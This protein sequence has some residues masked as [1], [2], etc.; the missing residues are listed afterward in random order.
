MFFNCTSHWAIVNSMSGIIITS[1]R[2]GERF[3]EL[4]RGTQTGRRFEKHILSTG[5]LLYP[6]VAGGK[7]NIDE[8]FLDTMIKNFNNKVCDIV[9]LPVA[10]SKNEHTED[11]L[12]NIGEVIQLTKRNGKLYAEMDVRDDTAAPKVGKTLL[13]S[14]AMLSLDYTD[15]RIGKGVGPTL[16]HVAITNRPFVVDLDDFTEL[17]AASADGEKDAVF[18][19]APTKEKISMDLDDYITGLRDEHGID[20]T[21]LQATAA[22]A[23]PTLALSHDLQTLLGGT[24]VLTL[25]NGAEATSEEI[26]SA[27]T[28]ITE[29]NVSLTSRVDELVLSGATSVATAEVE[30]LVRTGHIKPV[31]K[32]AMLELRLSNEE[33]FKKLVPAKPLVQ[34]SN[35]DEIG[36]VPTDLSHD[37]T[38]TAEIARLSA[39][40]AAAAYINP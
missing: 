31:D 33:L 15:T 39:S 1:P 32:D 36:F 12:R 40:P 35:T 3:V 25:S 9:Q 7:V 21:A 23:A 27:V 10:G 34:L 6:K 8:A 37:D 13:G 18:L 38:V 17:I 29:Q 22:N 5:P 26:I 24:G 14:S 28:A 20:V 30:G 19:T 2:D 16:L 11:P 4:S